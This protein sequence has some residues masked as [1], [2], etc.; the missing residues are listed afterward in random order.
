[1]KKLFTLLTLALISI[2]SAWGDCSFTFDGTHET[3]GTD[4]SG[5]GC[6]ITYSNIGNSGTNVKNLGTTE[7]PDNYY[8]FTSDNAYVTIK[9]STAYDNFEVGDVLTIVA[10]MN[11]ESA[12]KGFIIGSARDCGT[13]ITATGTKAK[14]IFTFTL[15]A[16]SINADG[17]ITLW[18]KDS[19]TFIQSVS[20]SHTTATVV[21]S[22]PAFSESDGAITGGTEI[23][24]SGSG[25]IFYQWSASASAP[26]IPADAS[27]PGD[28]TKGTTA[29]VPNEAGAKYLYAFA[30]N[31]AGN[32]TIAV[33]SY[34]VSAAILPPELSYTT[35]SYTVLKGGSF[36][37]PTLNN[38]HSLT[39]TYSLTGDAGVATVDAGT[40]D[41]SLSG[42][43]GTV[44]IT[45][46]YAGGGGYEIGEASYTLSV[47]ELTAQ[48]NKFWNFTTNTDFQAN[49][50]STKIIDDL[51]IVGTASYNT[52]SGKF[53]GLSLEKYL[54]VTN[55][56]SSNYFHFKVS[57]KCLIT[58][59]CYGNGSNRKVK[60]TSG[61][62]SG[63]QLLEESVAN[64]GTDQIFSVSYTG[65]EAENIYVY[66]SGSNALEVYGIKVEPATVSVPVGTTGWSTYSSA[67]ALDFENAQEGIEAYVITG[68]EG[69]TLTTSKITGTVAANT[70]LLV[71]G[72]A[73]TDYNVPVVAAG[74]APTANLLVA[75][76]AGET[77]DAGTG[78][79][80]NYVLVNNSGTAEFQWIDETSATLGSNK[81]YLQ[82]VNGPK[83][84]TSAHGLTIDLD[85]EL[86]G[87]KNIK[88]GSED[89]IY[90]D[91]QGHRVL[92]PTKGLYIVNGKKVILK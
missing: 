77:V 62:Y 37:A 4:V 22:A 53:T 60:I 3:S 14:Q 89:N 1:M 79:N 7:D 84:E 41:V 44:T 30:K 9:L 57:G 59:Y 16:A 19:N 54:S 33:G 55:A 76:V 28:W 70:G 71:K 63:T 74:D 12:A 32:S 78:D 29:T 68:F 31:A 58:V 18:R 34:T 86:T 83:S 64:K 23:T 72:T 24:I 42:G 27:L 61:S 2:G 85:G 38:P 8:K 35:T 50:S 69:T 52:R 45:A 13:D 82:I 65:T 87:I 48:S 10:Y 25:V 40:G 43:T 11:S 73:D 20:V 47:V 36:D 17:T 88:V 56:S 21:P 92:Y 75:S 81:A 80:V 51:E 66:N 46:S 15:T 91:L 39:V 6:K 5:T 90:Y 67:Y 49:V 26:D